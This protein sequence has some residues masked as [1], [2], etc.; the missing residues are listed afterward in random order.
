MPTPDKLATDA[1]VAVLIANGLEEVEALAV[2]DVLYRAGIAVDMLAVGDD[3]SVTSS[4]RVTFRCDALLADVDLTD[5]ALVFL[6]GGVPG[7]PNLKSTRAVTDEV[8][9]RLE[10]GLPL[11]AICAAPSIPAEL[12][13]LAGRRAT[14]NPAFLRVLED[15]GAET[16]EDSVVIDDNLLTSRGMG[17]AID[18]GL[19]IV[20]LLLDDA[21]VEAVRKGIVYRR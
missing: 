16:S 7:T 2:V 1:R 15:N 11:A 20:R 3:L 10:A 5:Y 14:A 12:G 13:L 4:H 21:A 8:T 9:R 17:T 19:K 18:L 6:P